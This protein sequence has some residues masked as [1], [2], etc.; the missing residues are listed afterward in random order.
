LRLP[1]AVWVLGFDSLAPDQQ[2][3]LQ[4]CQAAGVELSSWTP[5]SPARQIPHVRVFSDI[6]QEWSRIARWARTCIEH[7]PAAGV[8]IVVPDLQRQRSRIERHLQ[9]VLYPNASAGSERLPGRSFHISLG[10]PLLDVPIVSAALRMLKLVVGGAL[11]LAEYG[12]LLRTP[13]IGGAGR[14]LDARSMLDA[15]L[16]E[17]SVSEVQFRM[18]GSLSAARAVAACPVWLEIFTRVQALT[19]ALRGRRR[20]THWSSTFAACLDGFGWPGDRPLD[21]DEHQAVEAWQRLL[22]QLAGLAVVAPEIGAPGALEKLGRMAAQQVFQVRAEPA[23]IQVLGILEAAGLRFSQ[24]W[25]AGLHDRAWPPPAHPNPFLPIAMQKRAGIHQADPA[26]HLAHAAKLLNRVLACADA[27][28]ISYARHHGEHTQQPSSLIEALPGVAE[29]PEPVIPVSEAPPA[30]EAV[31]D[32]FGLRV[33]GNSAGG[34]GLFKDQAACPFRAYARYRL[35]A[36]ALEQSEPGLGA[37]ERGLLMHQLLHRVWQSLR[38]HQELVAQS[39]EALRMLVQRHAQQVVDGVWRASLK[40]GGARFVALEV[41]RLVARSLEL[42]QLECTRAP[43]S[44]AAAE[45]AL[46]VTLGELRVRVRPDRVDRLADGTLLVLDYK[47]GAVSVA[48]WFGQRPDDPQ[49]PLYVCLLG[50]Q[51]KALAFVSLKKGAVGYAGI[52]AVD[53]V[54]DGVRAVADR[55]FREHDDW[56][57]L[58]AHWISVT[59]D[60]ADGYARGDAVVDPKRGEQTCRYC[61]IRPLCRVDASDDPD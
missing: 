43:F 21:S 4:R 10:V 38:T 55:R 17:R 36:R 23:S 20:M 8:G 15:W 16:R 47:T 29:P 31:A 19:D 26:A 57:A 5:V 42:L 52:S 32:R 58:V 45:S 2:A 34:A 61:D 49:L 46:Q 56:N 41:Q 1:R 59:E 54:A 39:A 50:G 13:F 51:V 3:W 44:V 14:E 27:R 28:T 11:P 24:L 33:T 6:D 60:L 30:L 48:D 40:P 12:A 18:P 7:D 53:G 35:G 25:I 37:R 22:E 9:D